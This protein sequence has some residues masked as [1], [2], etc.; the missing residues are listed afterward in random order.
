MKKRAHSENVSSDTHVC[1]VACVPF[2]VHTSGKNTHRWCLFFFFFLLSATLNAGISMTFY[3]ETK[4]ICLSHE[5]LEN[6]TFTLIISPWILWN[7]LTPV[8]NHIHYTLLLQI[9]IPLA[10]YSLILQAHF[11]M[12]WMSWD[13]NQ[14]PPLLHAKHQV[15]QHVPGKQKEHDTRQLRQWCGYHIPNFTLHLPPS[16]LGGEGK[17]GRGLGQKKIKTRMFEKSSHFESSLLILWREWEYRHL[18]LAPPTL[19]KI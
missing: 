13:P 11:C 3:M 18:L 9:Q 8:W 5:H 1:T 7:C 10:L 17:M 16:C 4:E 12:V 6:M 15:C 19:D 14:V 2:S